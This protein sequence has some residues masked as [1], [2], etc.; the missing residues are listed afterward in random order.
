M[1]GSDTPSALKYMRIEN[2]AGKWY[3]TLGSSFCW[4][5]FMNH[6]LKVLGLSFLLFWSIPSSVGA[7]PDE[8][9]VLKLITEEAKKPEDKRDSSHLKT[10]ADFLF[11]KAKAF[12]VK[13]EDVLIDEQPDYVPTVG[14]WLLDKDTI[15]VSLATLMHAYQASGC[16]F[17]ISPGKPNWTPLKLARGYSVITTYMGYEAPL[18]HIYAR[19]AGFYYGFGI[20]DDYLFQNG[21]FKLIRSIE[22]SATKDIPE[23]IKEDTLLEKYTQTTLHDIDPGISKLYTTCAEKGSPGLD[24]LQSWEKVRFVKGDKAY[25]HEK[26]DTATQKGTYIIKGDAIFVSEIKGDWVLAQYLNPKTKKT[27]Q[28]YIKSEDLEKL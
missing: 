22:T 20:K 12:A 9:Q 14:L 28:G 21:T 16:L 24:H 23:D 25:F 7:S 5:G 4:E 19:S 15:L 13:N 17:F 10:I 6:Y 3:K 8:K 26:P 11:Q 2:N 18:L 1:A 27:L